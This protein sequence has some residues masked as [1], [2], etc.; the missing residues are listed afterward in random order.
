M[1]GSTFSPKPFGATGDAFDNPILDAA[2]TEAAWAKTGW[3]DLTAD[4]KINDNGL[5]RADGGLAGTAVVKQVDIGM[6]AGTTQA[7]F[8]FQDIVGGAPTAGQNVATKGDANK[9]YYDGV[10][11]SEV[12]SPVFDL[13]SDRDQRL[14]A[15]L[16][17][18]ARQL[19]DKNATSWCARQHAI[20]HHAALLRGANYSLL[21]TDKG[22][23]AADVGGIVTEANGISGSS[24][25][26]SQALHEI[27]FVPGTSISEQTDG[28]SNTTGGTN[29]R[30]L[31]TDT[32]AARAA[33]E[34]GV[35]RDLAVLQGSAAGSTTCLTRESLMGMRYWAEEYDI[36]PLSGYDWDYA[37]LADYACVAGLLQDYG[38]DS[39]LDIFRLWATGNK[40]MGGMSPLDR[41]IQNIVID[42]IKII[43]D[44]LLRAFRP[45]N[46]SGIAASATAANVVYGGTGTTVSTYTENKHESWRTNN[47]PVGVAFLLGDTALLKAKDGGVKM[48]AE[49]GA[50][51]TG[52]SVGTREFRSLRRAA[53]KAKDPGTTGV[54]GSIKQ[55][56]SMQGFFRIPTLGALAG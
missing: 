22:G 38:N 3:V 30:R 48:M 51:E 20:D 9:F 29:I 18:D 21:T 14:T 55:L 39:L 23:L 33:H 32:A 44:R 17:K 34:Q 52:L 7:R 26:G 1:A 46:I 24:V 28:A 36:R 13:L 50:F 2:L 16:I 4:V 54:S 8:A 53:W 56:G 37:L 35:A 6:K 41:R 49:P 25:G 27:V 15:N 31:V 12:R 11:I 10:E 47:G 40:D 5:V 42:G 43:P 45:A 19:A